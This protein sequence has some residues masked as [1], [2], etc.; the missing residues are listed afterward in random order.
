MWL[1]PLLEAARAV[2]ILIAVLV[3]GRF[4]NREPFSAF[5]FQVSRG[6]WLDCGVGVVLGGLLIAGVFLAERLA[7]WVRVTATL[8]SSAAGTSFGI[9]I[10]APVVL[11]A[12][13]ALY[14]EP[15]FRGYPIRNLGQGL[16]GTPLGTRGAIVLIWVLTSAYFGQSHSGNPGW[17][18]LGG[19]NIALAGILFGVGYVCTGRLGLSLGLHFGWDFCQGAVFGF[20]VAGL[21][22]SATAASVLTTSQARTNIWTG[23]TFG[24]DGGLLVTIAFLIGLVPVLLYIRQREGAVRVHTPLARF[25]PSLATRPLDG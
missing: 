13:A 4:L 3:I 10:L 8:H 22:M 19:A 25:T 6:W 12:A 24:P 18:V 11:V 1:L 21:K 5:G 7:G 17:T 14:E 20:P 16:A 23:T 9:A 15:Y 2:A